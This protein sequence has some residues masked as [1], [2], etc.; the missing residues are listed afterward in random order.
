MSETVRIREWMD[1]H[2]SAE[3]KFL[4]EKLP[5]DMVEHSLDLLETYDRDYNSGHD[6]EPEYLNRVTNMLISFAKGNNEHMCTSSSNDYDLIHELNIYL[7][8]WL[9]QIEINK[10]TDV[11]KGGYFMYSLPK[12]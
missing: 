4:Y 11:E 10:D 7:D 8:G 9:Y 12:S 3:V 1:G 2:V 5:A 6:L